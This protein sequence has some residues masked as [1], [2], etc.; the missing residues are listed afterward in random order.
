MLG[1][2]TAARCEGAVEGKDVGFSAQRAELSLERTDAGITFMPKAP[3]VIT[4]N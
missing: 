4:V 3:A 1:F 2:A